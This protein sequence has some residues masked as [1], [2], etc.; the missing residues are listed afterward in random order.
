M[1]LLEQI[2]SQ[3][4]NFFSASH[5][6]F[7]FDKCDR[8]HGHNYSVSVNFKYN[9]GDMTS[10]IDFRI[11][12]NA[13][14]NELELLNQKILLPKNSQKI[15]I[16]SLPNDKNW[17]ILVNDSKTYSFPK[18]DVII[19]D[20]IE[21]ITT[22]SLAYYLHLKLSSWLRQNYPNLIITLAI[23]ITESPGNHAKFSASL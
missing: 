15:V 20:G 4:N 18:N 19:L 8:L 17:Q 11:V 14:K 10:P 22:E 5:F 23:L 9:S 12:N 2:F 7:G 6:L 1:P 21:Q 16:S 13:I 3:I